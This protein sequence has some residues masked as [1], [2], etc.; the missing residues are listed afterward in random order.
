MTALTACGGGGSTTPGTTTATATPTP[1]P[2][3][4]D[5]TAQANAVVQQFLN[6]DLANLDN[7]AAPT[8]PA[9][10]DNTVD[11]ID[12]TPA[13]DP[14]TDP[15]ATLGRVLFYDAALSVNDTTS[16]ATCHQQ[17]IGFD[18]DERLSTGFQ[19][20]LT[21]AHAMRLGNIRYYEP[22]EMFWDRRADDVE[23]Q[24]TQPILDATE[25]GWSANGGLAALI[26]KME[27]LAYYPT[28]FEFVF[29]DGAITEAR[30]ERSLAQ[31]QRAMISSDSRWD[32]S[33]AQIFAAGAPGRALNQALPGFTASE[34][35]GRELFMTG[36]NNGGA[37]CQTC[38]QPPTF[39]LNANSR[40]NGLDAGETEVFKS[41][42][43]K[44]VGRS[45]FFM[46]DGRFTTLRQVV[47]HYSDGVQAGPALDNR[48]QQG[49]VPRRLNLT[50]DDREAL[51][52]FMETLTD[53]TLAA[54]ARFTDPFIR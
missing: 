14:V 15:I 10:Y 18:D 22:G 44:N 25:M 50:I 46:H 12:N 1:T 11:A 6:L 51:V 47:D 38:H 4:T 16:C 28:L 30:I 53:D 17:N 26:T 3:P 34:Q 42:S 35:R 36:V 41:P 37:G 24:A 54:D 43:L 31:F 9:Y 45:T 2:T 5:S 39:A 13:N 33:Y 7:Y 27:G 23:D 20:G 52:D 21:S 49:G 29:G 48:L 40:S 32:Q 8:L 19:G